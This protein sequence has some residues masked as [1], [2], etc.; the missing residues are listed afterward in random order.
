VLPVPRVLHGEGKVIQHVYFPIEGVVSMLAS[1]EGAQSKVEVGTVGREG[2]LGLSVLFGAKHSHGDC[3]MQV[4][5]EGW[6]MSV[7]DFVRA[8]ESLPVFMRVLHRYAH[9]LFVQVSQAAACNRVHSAEQRCARWI[10]M[11]RDRVSSDTF[12]LTQQFL[13][14]MLGE[15]RATVSKAASTLKDLGL[16]RYSR[17]KVSVLDRPRLEAAACPCYEVIRREYDS[18]LSN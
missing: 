17:G 12:T 9:A 1:A 5:G 6:R 11:T 8:A 4:D 18:I 15:R 7:Q 3:F 14:H 13:G 16:V 2:M 10:L